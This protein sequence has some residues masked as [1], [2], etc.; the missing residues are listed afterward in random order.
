MLPH[1]EDLQLPLTHGETPPPDGL[2]WTALFG[3]PGPNAVEIGAGNG[4]FIENEAA[5]LPDWNFIGIERDRTFYTK[6]MRR[7]WRR[8]LTNV[9]TTSVD[10]FEV[11]AALPAQ[12]VER[13]YLYFSDPWPKRRHAARRVFGDPFLAACE[14]ALTPRGEI[15]FKTDVG[16]YF[17]QAV[18][19]ARQHAGWE[20]KDVAK[21]PPPDESA[22][23]IYSNYERKAREQGIEVWGFKLLHASGHGIR[24]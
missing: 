1:P 14:R 8:G 5:R 10:A 20:L 2:D 6:M 23:E 18:T 15:W 9:R 11:L 21:L 12:S 4:Y 24:L 17:N 3:R 19:V 13:L 22:G 16:W 7:C